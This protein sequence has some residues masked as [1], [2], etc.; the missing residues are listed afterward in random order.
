MSEL[1][2]MRPRLSRSHC[3]SAGDCNAPFQCI[4][5]WLRA[6]LIGNGSEQ[7]KARSHGLFAGIHQHETAGAVSIFHLS[8]IEAGLAYQSGLL[9]AEGATDRNARNFSG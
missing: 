6:K 8:R 9:I 1:V 5:G 3:T 7:A 4:A 2:S